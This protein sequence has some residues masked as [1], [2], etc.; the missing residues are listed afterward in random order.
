MIA[1]GHYKARAIASDIGV[2]QTKGTPFVKV[3]FKLIDQDDEI[4]WFGYVPDNEAA[5]DRL[6]KDLKT[7]GYKGNNPE[8]LA[9]LSE[10]R[11]GEFLPATVS[12]KI[13]HEEFRDQLRP[14]VRF[15]NPE[16]KTLDGK[17]SIFGDMRAAFASLGGAPAA[18]KANGRPAPIARP[19]HSEVNEDD[20]PFLGN[21]PTPDNA[22]AS[23][24]NQGSG[25][26]GVE[27]TESLWSSPRSS[28]TA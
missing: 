18:P 4:D 14:R 6:A 19:Q 25:A 16:K 8:E 21:F 10:E 5:R 2:S 27:E 3:T 22:P 11:V 7:L 23:L 26:R 28:K 12:L 13:E 15:I 17:G 20:L 1:E 24:E 9:N